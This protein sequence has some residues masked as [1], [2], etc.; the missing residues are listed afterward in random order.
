MSCF[1]SALPIVLP[2]IRDLT[3][4]NN[5]VVILIVAY[6][7]H[8]QAL[9]MTTIHE[10]VVTRAEFADPENLLNYSWNFSLKVQELD[11]S[12]NSF[13]TIHGT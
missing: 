1:Q 3:P 12:P 2:E 9:N 5:H 7:S 11:C 4:P 8:V 13:S 6:G 10:G